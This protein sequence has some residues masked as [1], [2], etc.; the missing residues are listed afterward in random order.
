MWALEV[1]LLTLQSR[2][3]HS[4]GVLT[5]SE[6]GPVEAGVLRL[7]REGLGSGQHQRLDVIAAECCAGT[8]RLMLEVTPLSMAVGFG[9]RSCARCFC[10]IGLP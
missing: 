6:D 8:H 7:S 3:F 5:K 1:M 2:D 4:C 10:G 9:W